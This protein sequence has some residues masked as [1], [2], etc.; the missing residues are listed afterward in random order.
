MRFLGKRRQG[1]INSLRLASLNNF[2]RVWTIG[3]VSSC[4]VSGPFPGSGMIKAEEY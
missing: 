2:S 1:R 4:L 3:V